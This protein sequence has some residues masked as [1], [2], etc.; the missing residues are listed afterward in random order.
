M[1]FDCIKKCNIR[2][3]TESQ[4]RHQVVLFGTVFLHFGF[5]YFCY[6]LM[7]SDMPPVFHFF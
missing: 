7:V 4:K 3:W 1:N 6:I 2:N 5:F